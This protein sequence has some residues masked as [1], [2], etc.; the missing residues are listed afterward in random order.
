MKFCGSL[1]IYNSIYKVNKTRG[2]NGPYLRKIKKHSRKENDLYYI[3]SLV[4][5][6]YYHVY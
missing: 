1:S 6:H 4:P 3:V 5:L 2:V